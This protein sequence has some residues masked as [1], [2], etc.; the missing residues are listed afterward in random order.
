MSYIVIEIQTNSDGTVGN[1]V[2]AYADRMQAEQQYHTVLASAAVSALPVHAAVLLTNDGRL[3]ASQAY[4][5][6]EDE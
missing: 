2:N 5:H 4:H 1:L 3:I 6:G